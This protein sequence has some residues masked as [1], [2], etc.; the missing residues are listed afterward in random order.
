MDYDMADTDSNNCGIGKAID[1]S[2]RYQI[3]TVF[4]VGDKLIW[5]GIFD[6]VFLEHSLEDLI[7]LGFMEGLVSIGIEITK[8]VQ[9]EIF[10]AIP[11]YGKIPKGVTLYPGNKQCD[12]HTFCQQSTKQLEKT[13]LGIKD[14]ILLSYVI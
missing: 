14:T 7:L 5:K 9:Q 10:Q 6:K 4:T 8:T 3:S 1:S 11:Y 12:S 2:P 13:K